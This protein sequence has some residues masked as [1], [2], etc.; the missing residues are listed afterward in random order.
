M[1]KFLSKMNTGPLFI[2]LAAFL[3]TTDAFVRSNYDSILTG[4]QIVLLEHLIIVI[5]I[6]PLIVKYIPKLL[7]LTKKEWGAVLFIGIGG[8]ALATVAFTEGIFI[9]SPFQFIAVVILLQQ[10]QPLIA[11]GLS[12]LLLKE[13]LP[14]FYYPL[15]TVSLIGVFLIIFPT[16]SG[17]TQSVGGL[18][19][20]LSQLTSSNG[21][22][23]GLLGLTAAFLWGSSTV[24]G[25]YV[26]EHGQQ[27]P[28]YFQMVTYRFFI[29]FIF[30]LLLIPFYSRS[31]LIEMGGF[32]NLSRYPSFEAIATFSLLTGLIYIALIVGLLSL[33][34][35]YY[36]LK[37]THASMSAIAE[38]AFPLSFFMIIPFLQSLGTEIIFPDSIQLLGSILLISSATLL[39]YNYGKL[40]QKQI[41]KEV[42]I[43]T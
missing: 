11:I 37:T 22:L 14:N 42:I 5:M 35:Y 21:F 30:L 4:I 9:G 26:M 17:F 12:H 33:L 38:L 10:T 13:R 25:R 36:G 7:E 23:A 8:S 20:T 40:F 32:L 16:I 19:N 18:L 6:S 24:F 31:S 43:T 39:S 27:K 34:L 2:A 3:W 15:A 29:A 28:A 1:V 41:K